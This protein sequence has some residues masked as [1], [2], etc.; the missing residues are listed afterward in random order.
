MRATRK[1]PQLAGLARPCDA[2]GVAREGEVEI[3]SQGPPDVLNG[4][5]LPILLEL[6]SVG[7]RVVLEADGLVI[8]QAGRLSAHQ[9]DVIERHARELA[10][11]VRCC[12]PAVGERRDAFRRQLETAP[13][14]PLV[15]RA[16]VTY[17]EGTCYSCG[18]S[19]DG[20][21]IGTCWRC[22]LGRRL[23]CRAPIP[24]D[25]LAPLERAISRDGH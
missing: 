13:G 4:P 1:T 21:R 20:F 5:A 14:G 22:S 17:V 6:E 2:I 16:F 25:L 12:D 15:F 3:A 11:L 18:E 24:S 8:D 19:L 9:R 10:I 23:A 7:C